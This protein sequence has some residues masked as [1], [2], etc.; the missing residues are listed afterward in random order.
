M[1]IRVDVIALLGLCAAQLSN[2][3]SLDLSREI[4]FPGN[5]RVLQASQVQAVANWYVDLRNSAIGIADVSVY[6]YS[7]KGSAPHADLGKGRIAAV[8]DLVKTLGAT[9]PVPV[10]SRVSEGSSERATQFPEVVVGVQP[11][12]AATRSCCG[13]PAE[14]QRK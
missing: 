12:C 14:P 5:T 9:D 8:T 13:E 10:R 4:A 6:A 3:C 7:I 11:K 2:A 1:K